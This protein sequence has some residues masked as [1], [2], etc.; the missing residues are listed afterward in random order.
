MDEHCKELME[1]LSS[2]LDGEAESRE[3][4]EILAHLEKCDCCRHC[5]ETLKATR[6][7]VQTMPAPEMPRD[8]KNRLKACLK[9]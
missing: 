7:M 5:Y 3:V 9:K 4:E 2:Y 6:Q 8:L 1:K